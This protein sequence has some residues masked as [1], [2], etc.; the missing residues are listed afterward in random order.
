V[1]PVER[2]ADRL[3]LPAFADLLCEA[4]SAAANIGADAVVRVPGVLQLEALPILRL[5][6]RVPRVRPSRGINIPT[7]IH[8]PA[9]ENSANYDN[10]KLASHRE[11]AVRP[12]ATIPDMPVTSMKSLRCITF[13]YPDRRRHVR[14]V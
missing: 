1:N 11:R 2:S 14:I 6:M 12:A 7:R 10:A 8:A 13:D 3:A 4:L 9:Q 5:G